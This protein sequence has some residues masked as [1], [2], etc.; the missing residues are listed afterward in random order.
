MEVYQIG[1]KCIRPSTSE[2]QST[3][4]SVSLCLTTFRYLK[5]GGFFEHI[6]IDWTPRSV[7][8]YDFPPD[9]SPLLQW[10]YGL[11]DASARI[12]KPMSY[13]NNTEQLLD[14]AGFS[15]RTHETIRVPV[16]SYLGDR[17]EYLLCSGFKGAIKGQDH[18]P[19]S[20]LIGMSMIPFVSAYG[21]SEQQIRQLCWDA[22]NMLFSMQS[23][24]YFNL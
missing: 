5:P 20:L 10:W 13:P 14:R 2:L 17:S 9:T 8:G 4:R 22:H 6:E 18:D 23:P 7:P 11:E 16:P 12:G 24:V 1:I 15:S 19:A 3:R 21:W